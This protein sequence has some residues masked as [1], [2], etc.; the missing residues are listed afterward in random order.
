MVLEVTRAIRAALPKA[1]IIYGGVFP[2]YHWSEILAEA[3]QIDVIV[4]GEGEET[5]PRLM[6]ALADNAPL[7]AIPGIA[8][9]QEGMAGVAG[10]AAMPTATRP[11]PL[12]EDLDA[13][14]VG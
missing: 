11:A 5:T 9:R 2:T 12:V 3:P 10:V 6:E 14:R 7:D 13:C 4:R 8:W 1:W